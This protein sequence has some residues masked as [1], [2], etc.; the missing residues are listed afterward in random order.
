MC[1]LCDLAKA[2]GDNMPEATAEQAKAKLEAL[3]VVKEI[4]ETFRNL[5]DLVSRQKGA[6]QAFKDAFS[7]IILPLLTGVGERAQ[8]EAEAADLG[9]FLSL[10]FGGL[11]PDDPQVKVRRL[12]PDDFAN[13]L[14][15][16]KLP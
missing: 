14:R 3:N 5:A 13:F 1:K 12:T 2:I 15:T 9:A 16:G 11:T 8:D 7:G 10:L 6:P 4:H